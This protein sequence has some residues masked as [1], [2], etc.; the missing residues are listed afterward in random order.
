MVFEYEKPDAEIVSFLSLAQLARSDDGD[1]TRAG[2][3][4][5]AGSDLSVDQGVDED[6]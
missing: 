6:F 5:N 2:E 3:G 1:R 4:G